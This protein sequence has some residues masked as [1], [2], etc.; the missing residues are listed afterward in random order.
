[1]KSSWNESGNYMEK[2]SART[3]NPCPV[4]E[5]GLGFTVRGAKGPKNQQNVHVIEMELQPGLKRQRERAFILA[6]AE[7]SHVIETIHNS[8]LSTGLKFT[9]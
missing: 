4:W 9:I 5:T 2:V 8:A 6:Q 7:N 3:E 1:M